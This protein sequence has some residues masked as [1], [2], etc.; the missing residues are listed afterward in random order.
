MDLAERVVLETH[1]G[2]E[3][4]VLDDRRTLRRRIG[5][6]GNAQRH[7]AVRVEVEA[8]RLPGPAGRLLLNHRVTRKGDGRLIAVSSCEK[9]LAGDG[10]GGD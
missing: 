8:Y 2:L 1:A 10:G 3:P 9:L 4:G 6:Y 7:D 5:F